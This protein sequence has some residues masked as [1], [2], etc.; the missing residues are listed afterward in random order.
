MTKTYSK[1]KKFS[2]SN[3]FVFWLGKNRIEGPHPTGS[4]TTT[5]SLAAAIFLNA[6]RLLTWRRATPAQTLSSSQ[7]A[8][9]STAGHLVHQAG[10]FLWRVNAGAVPV[11]IARG[12][13][14]VR[15]AISYIKSEISCSHRVSITNSGLRTYEPY[16]LLKRKT[17]FTI[18]S[19]AAPWLP[20][21]DKEIHYQRLWT[22]HQCQHMEKSILIKGTSTSTLNMNPRWRKNI[23]DQQPSGPRPA[24]RAWKIRDA[25]M[26]LHGWGRRADSLAH[27]KETSLIA[28]RVT[29][30]TGWLSSHARERL[31]VAR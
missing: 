16:L 23:P 29:E 17:I 11:S 22:N 8:S 7:G 20:I 28:L 31:A 18:R 15:P 13:Q 5:R 12:H 25:Q 6:V 26:A 27:V 19:R 30:T 4:T 21:A 14:L 9:T 3:S 2:I 10:H 1:L 24:V